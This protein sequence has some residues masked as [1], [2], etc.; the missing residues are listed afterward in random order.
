MDVFHLFF[1]LSE[2]RERKRLVPGEALR[3]MWGRKG[4]E[5]SV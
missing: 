5:G 4:S 3:I 1:S 2:G